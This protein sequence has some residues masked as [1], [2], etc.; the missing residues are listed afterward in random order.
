MS[1]SERAN[2]DWPVQEHGIAVD[3]KAM[4]G[5]AAMAVTR[6]TGRDDDQ[7]LKFTHDGKFLMQIG[8]TGKSKGS[9]DT[10]NLGH[11]S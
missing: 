2:F 6:K 10:E 1:E 7:C 5:S 9:L 3:I 11:P 8:H 4:S